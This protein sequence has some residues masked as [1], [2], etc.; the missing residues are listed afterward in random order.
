MVL[1][2]YQLDIENPVLTMQAE[3]APLKVMAYLWRYSL[4]SQ[5]SAGSI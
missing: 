2:H 3:T 1:P 4:G 5:M